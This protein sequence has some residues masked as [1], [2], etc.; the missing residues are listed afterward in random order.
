MRSRVLVGFCCAALAAAT[1]PPVVT[2]SSGAVQGKWAINGSSEFLAIPFATPPLASLRWQPPQPVKPWT[3]VR[4]GSQ[5]PSP[6]IQTAEPY[7]STPSEDCLYVNVFAPP[8][9]DFSDPKPTRA[10]MVFIYGGSYIS[11]ASSIPVYD[12]S[13]TVG[14]HDVVFVSLNYRLGFLGYGG[15]D[16]LRAS[17]NSTGNFGLQDQ[18]A[19]VQWVHDNIAKFGGDSSRIFLFGESAGSGSTMVHLVAPRSQGLMA[20][21]GLESGPAVEW[22]AKTLASSET[23]FNEVVNRSS[24]KD[25]PRSELRKCLESLPTDQILTIQQEIPSQP[26]WSPVIDGVELME[27]PVNSFEAG[28]IV[29]KVPL[30]LGSNHDE[31]TLFNRLPKNV[32]LDAVDELI[33]AHF[34]DNAFVNKVEAAY[35][36]SDFPSPWWLYAAIFGDQAFTCPTRRT[37]RWANAVGMPVYTYFFTHVPVDPTSPNCYGACHSSELPFV[38][39][40]PFFEH[41]SNETTLGVHMN[42]YWAAFAQ[43]HT[44]TVPGQPTWDLYSS[45]SGDNYLQLD[46]D[47]H[48]ISG[49]RS[50]KCDLF[51]QWLAA[52]PN[53]NH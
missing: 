51:D 4:D 52:H 7:F 5:W 38:F 27:H 44:P 37:S 48:M 17:D 9:V 31:G 30:L 43:H 35:K 25:I 46:F 11:G 50:A 19:A 24:C 20:A 16:D 8:S 12:G 40:Q 2:L 29:N 53:P 47:I 36:P 18:R 45:G 33:S 23:M 15:S 39:S 49:L 13:F 42:A 28:R 1:A 14:V 41:G 21:A 10:V 22:T 34:N 26:G 3:G 6:C 32:S